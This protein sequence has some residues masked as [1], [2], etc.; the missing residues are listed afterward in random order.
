MTFLETGVEMN[1]RYRR[2]EE[3]AS[4]APGFG[5]YPFGPISHQF[6]PLGHLAAFPA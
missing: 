6:Q 3:T 5:G 4:A 1:T 2:I